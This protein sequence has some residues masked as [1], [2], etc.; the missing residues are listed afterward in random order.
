MLNS[1]HK[2]F[3]MQLEFTATINALVLTQ[4]QIASNAIEVL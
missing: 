2:Y 3:V 1:S 4:L